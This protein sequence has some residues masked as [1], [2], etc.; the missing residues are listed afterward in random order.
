MH[1][2]PEKQPSFLEFYQWL[3][4]RHGAYLRFTARAGVQYM[5]EMWFDQ[6]F[7]QTWRN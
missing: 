7:K 3:E 1:I 6:E 4:E 5:I 2:P